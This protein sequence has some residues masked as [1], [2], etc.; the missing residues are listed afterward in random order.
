MFYWIL[1]APPGYP[2][3]QNVMVRT[4]EILEASS[5]GEYVKNTDGT[6]FFANLEDARQVIPD[7]AT[8]PP[9]VRYAPFLEIW[10]GPRLERN[11]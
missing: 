1:E 4:S 6:F 9:F 2:P 3:L 10:E 5:L 7:G 11:S 8:Q